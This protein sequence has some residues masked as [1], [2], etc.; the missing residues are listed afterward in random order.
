MR[1]GKPQSGDY[2]EVCFNPNI[3]ELS[4]ILLYHYVFLYEYNHS[5][6]V[7]VYHYVFY[8]TIVHHCVYEIYQHALQYVLIHG[9]GCYMLKAKT[10]DVLYS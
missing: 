3:K 2:D 6:L 8:I 4:I 10:K 9:E 1:L 7:C 5:L